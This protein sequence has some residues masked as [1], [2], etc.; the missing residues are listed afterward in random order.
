MRISALVFA[1]SL[2]L[3]AVPASAQ[4]AAP[5]NDANR[6]YTTLDLKQCKHTRGRDVEDYGFW[7]CTGYAGI[8]VRVSAGDQRTYISYGANAAKEPAAKQTLASFNSEG[9]TIEWRLEKGPDGKPRPYATIL[10]WN[11][12][13]VDDDNPDKPFAGQVLVVTR[14]APGSTCHVGYVDARAN[15]NANDLARQIADES[16]RNFKCG[17]DKPIVLGAKGKGFSGPYGED[18]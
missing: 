15:P 7:R 9:K 5:A 18:N 4:P 6:A 17:T 16:A 2:A 3:A 12:T 11:T 14:L 8:P 1:A 10:R 13:K